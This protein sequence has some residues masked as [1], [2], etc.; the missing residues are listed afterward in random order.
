MKKKKT[1][2]HTHT[3]WAQDVS[4]LEPLQLTV[5]FPLAILGSPGDPGGDVAVAMIILRPKRWFTP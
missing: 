4:R 3:P 1:H 2:T 5:D